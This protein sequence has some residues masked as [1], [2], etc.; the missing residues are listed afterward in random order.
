MLLFVATLMLYPSTGTAASIQWKEPT[1]AVQPNHEW[2]ISFNH[3]LNASSVK[4]TTVYVTSA[5]GTKLTTNA[6]VSP[7]NAK[8]IL[9]QPP[10]DGYEN[11]KTYTLHINQSITSNPAN[12]QLKNSVEMKFSIASVNYEKLVQGTWNT[13]HEGYS[14]VIRLN[15]NFTYNMTS[16]I[17]SSGKYI[18][19]GSRMTLT[20]FGKSVTGEITKV[21]DEKF[22]ITSDSGKIMQFTK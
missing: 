16:P 14:I 17:T 21:S 2:K 9:V 18:L 19:N 6:I 4:A 15:D 20:M 8:I 1:A 5:D 12:E 22:L 11:G 10:K 3:S 13:S 7:S